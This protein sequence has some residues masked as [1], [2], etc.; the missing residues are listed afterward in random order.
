MRGSS[1]FK[2]GKGATFREFE[3]H[4]LRHYNKCCCLRS[5]AVATLTRRYTMRLL[6]QIHLEQERL[7]AGITFEILE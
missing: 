7:V 3:S 5:S 4:P 6:R 2:T 1:D